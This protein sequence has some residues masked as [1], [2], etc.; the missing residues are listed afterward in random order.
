M[1]GWTAEHLTELVRI[2]PTTTVASVDLQLPNNA[3]CML[4]LTEM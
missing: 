4:A 2:V 3:G 1:L